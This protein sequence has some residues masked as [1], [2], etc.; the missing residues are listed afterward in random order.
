MVGDGPSGELR[1]SPALKE[2]LR[3]SLSDDFASKKHTQ[4]RSRKT[5]NVHAHN[6][7]RASL[8]QRCLCPRS[9]ENPP[10]GLVSISSDQKLS[11]LN[12]ASLSKGPVSSFQTDHGNLTALR[13]FGDNVVCT[14]GENG[15]V[16]VWD[17]RAGAQVVQFATSE[18]PL[19][20]MACSPETQTIAVGT[21]LHN[22][23]A[24]IL[25]WDVRSAP[26]QKAAYH[27]LHSDDIT[28]LTYHP[29]NPNL[30][31]SGSTD[32]LVSV[33][34]TSIADED[35]LTVQTLNLN[36]SIHRAGFLGPSLVYALSHDERFAIYDI[37]E[38]QGS[39]MRSGTL[40]T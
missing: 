31:L 19:A 28:T 26:V 14:A 6:N 17:L 13:L 38:A 21:E 11:L 27:D 5:C 2:Q 29:S 30:L 25:L 34:D 8:R 35:E 18:A 7:R 20:S 36:A 37:S 16:G 12:P 22:H 3:K 32:G 4:N 15:N 39:G 23:E 33:H 40:A 1:T 24:S 10:G 9:P